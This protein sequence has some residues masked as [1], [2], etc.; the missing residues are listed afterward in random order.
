MR[1]NNE[2]SRCEFESTGFSCQIAVT[3][4]KIKLTSKQTKIS[5]TSSIN[6]IVI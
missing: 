2:D 4:P 1:Y 6:Q 5:I 3:R